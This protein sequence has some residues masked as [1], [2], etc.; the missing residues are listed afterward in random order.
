M[1]ICRNRKYVVIVVI[2][3]S[4]HSQFSDI[5][6]LRSPA[7]HQYPVFP[8][9]A[10]G[11][12]Y[13]TLDRGWGLAIVRLWWP[14]EGIDLASGAVL[15][16]GRQL[17][18]FPLHS[19]A[20]CWAPPPWF[21]VSGSINPCF[22]VIV[23]G[24]GVVGWGQGVCRDERQSKASQQRSDEGLRLPRCPL[25]ALLPLKVMLALWSGTMLTP[26]HLWGHTTWK[27]PGPFQSVVSRHRN[28]SLVSSRWRL[29]RL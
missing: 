26:T 22:Y 19:A 8:E 16:Y 5:L 7:T 17:L 10:N 21:Q 28:H 4:G 11:H 20:S 18:A 1:F 12:P 27:W 6:C 2:L 15:S 23:L 14:W 9:P 3:W 25:E 24:Y 13:L 29:P